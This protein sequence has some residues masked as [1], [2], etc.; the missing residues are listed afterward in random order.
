M[1]SI[2]SP[3]SKDESVSRDRIA[4]NVIFWSGFG[5][6]LVSSV[7]LAVTVAPIIWPPTGGPAAATP[8]R[9]TAQQIFNALIPLFGTWVGTVL[10]FYFSRENFEAAAKSTQDT[11]RLSDERLKQ[12]RVRDAWIP[13]NEIVGVLIPEGK[14]AKDVPFKAICEKLSDKVTRVPV[15]H[16]DKIVDYVLH[17]SMIYKY[18]YAFKD[19]QDASLEDFLSYNDM[20]SIVTKIGWVGEKSTLADAKAKM[21]SIEGCQDVFVTSDGT[22]KQPIL[23]WITNIEIAKKSRA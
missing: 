1:A 2:F 20:R 23:G 8:A 6:L 12:I 7:A 10:A 16:G 19:K 11:L 5:I 15:W 18:M 17:E 3:H 13:A 9:E 14:T 4:T 22:E 21:E